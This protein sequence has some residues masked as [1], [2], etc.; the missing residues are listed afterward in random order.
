MLLRVKDAAGRVASPAQ[1]ASMFIAIAPS[2]PPTRLFAQRTSRKRRRCTYTA[3]EPLNPLAVCTAMATR[4]STRSGTA[5]K[6]AKAAKPAKPPKTAPKASSATETRRAPA[7]TRPYWSGQL[8]LAL[9]ALPVKVYSATQSGGRLPLH[10]LDSKT[11]KRIRYEKVV[12]GVGPIDKDAIIKGYEYEKGSYV[13]LT[14]K[15]LD[16][17]K[18]ESRKTIELV[19]FVDACE[20]DPIY[21]EKPYYAVPD[22][23]LAEDGF[24]VI[25]EALRRTGK[26]GLGQMAL[27]GGESIVAVKPCGRGLLMETLRFPDEIRKAAPLFSG[28]EDEE[29]EADLIA[30]AEELIGRRSAPFDANRFKDNY[31]TALRELIERKVATGRTVAV[32]DEAAPKK[33]GGAKIIDL[34]DALKASVGSGKTAADEPAPKGRRGNA[35]RAA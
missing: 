19:Q 20:I 30:M 17:V 31:T 14:D 32:G 8:R 11:G 18:I 21:Y 33:G 22:G 4:S 3:T 28:I 27:R 23:D 16:A 34:M 9:V 1:V 2:A 5:A 15:D 13:T 26:V 24:I 25:R 7:P 35:G 10:Q 29:P 6:S 12:P